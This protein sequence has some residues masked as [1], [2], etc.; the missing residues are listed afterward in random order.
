[1]FPNNTAWHKARPSEKLEHVGSDTF[2]TTGSHFH[3]GLVRLVLSMPH[4]RGKA[5]A[6]VEF[7]HLF[8]CFCFCVFLVAF[9]FFFSS[10]LK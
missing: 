3:D 7:L 8:L 10:N 5:L 4:Q 6:S 1:M 2:W 9:F